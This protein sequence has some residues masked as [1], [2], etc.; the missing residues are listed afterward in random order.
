MAWGDHL[1]AVPASPVELRQ[2]P[3]P[4]SSLVL[5]RTPQPA[6]PHPGLPLALVPGASVYYNIFI[7]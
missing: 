5:P 1:A 2:E 7:Y 4:G 6:P 3:G